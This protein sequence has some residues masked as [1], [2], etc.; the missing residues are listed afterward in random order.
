MLLRKYL[1]LL[2]IGS[3]QIDL[4]LNNGTY[5]PGEKVE[6]YFRIKGGTIEQQLKRIE[7][8]LVLD[9]E[10]TGNEEVI[11][12]STILTSTTIASDGDSWFPFAFRLPDDLE[13]S[14][15]SR[16]YGFKTRLF[17]K[18]GVESVDHDE[19]QIAR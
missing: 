9:N 1:S 4:V 17:F 18:E 15:E 16:S 6:G 12:T 2:G 11:H 10:R 5:K 3:A 13:V 7:C 14:T 19:I 8:D